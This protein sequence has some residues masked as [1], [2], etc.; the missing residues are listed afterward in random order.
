MSADVSIVDAI[1]EMRCEREMAEAKTRIVE[2]VTA[3]EKRHGSFRQI[4]DD[5]C[6]KC[7]SR[8]TTPTTSFQCQRLLEGCGGSHRRNVASLASSGSAHAVR[9]RLPL[10]SCA[11]DGCPLGG[12]LA[13]VPFVRAHVEH[14]RSP[15]DVRDGE[16]AFHEGNLW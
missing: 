8:F 3:Y 2:A 14:V 9:F 6:P 10:C 13:E 15:Q 12:P 7:E 11:S 16:A 4:G 5:E 1:E